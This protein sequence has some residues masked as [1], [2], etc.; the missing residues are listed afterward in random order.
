MADKFKKNR[1]F[2]SVVQALF[3]IADAIILVAGDTDFSALKYKIISSAYSVLSVDVVIYADT[4][5]SAYS[6]TL[7]ASP[8]DKRF[9]II[10]NIGTSSNNLTVARNGNTIDGIASDFVLRD[11]DS[12]KLQFTS[13]GWKIN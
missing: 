1:G 10:K 2:G 4:N 8:S 12:I 7:E 3:K 6:V 13:L 5:A 9:I 11:N